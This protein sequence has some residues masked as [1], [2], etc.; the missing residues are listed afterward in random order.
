MEDNIVAISTAIGVGAISIVRISGK[1]SISIINDL[2]VGCDLTKVASHT[3]HYGYIKENDKIIDEVLVTVMKSP[4]T[5]TTEDIVEVNCHGG[6]IATNKVLKSILNKGVRLAEAG[7]FTKRAFLNGRID[8][9]Q[10]EAVMD[11]IESKTDSAR[12]QAVNQL[13]GKISSYIES[14]RLKIK[15]LLATIEVNIDYPEYY[16]IEQITIEKVKKVCQELEVEINQ[17]IDESKNGKIIKEGIKTVIVGRPNVG[18]SSILNNLIGEDKAIVTDI[19]GT[20]RDIIE[21]NIQ[22]DGIALNIIDTA[23]IRKTTNK[24]EEIGVQK[25]LNL[26]KEAD[27]IL[28]VLNSSESL[29]END[30][31]L[32]K[33]VNK[34]KTIIVLNK[35]DLKPKLTEKEFDGYNV[36]STNT[37]SIEGVNS[38]KS[39]IK[40]I[41]NLEKIKSSD[42]TSLTNIRQL[43]LA[44]QA[45]KTL[46]SAIKGVNNHLPIDMVAI[47]LKATFDLLGEIIGKTYSDEIINHLFENFC[48][49][50]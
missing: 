18:K 21:G 3:I 24:I 2:F 29:T 8:L 50:K 43:S 35:N 15:N 1:D 42:R 4:K 28:L 44:E 9:T 33:E 17:M 13:T 45:K 7:E 27:L 19:E 49:G 36:V 26:L 10:A 6:I 34:D 30:Y 5:F 39:K 41:F 32:L 48:V 37:L 16:D 14:L 47:D 12:N 46:Q 25:S 23:G 22:I 20:T 38:L 40:E 31:N 11:L